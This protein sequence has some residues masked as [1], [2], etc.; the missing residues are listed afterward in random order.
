MLDAL[1][2]QI[3]DTSVC[4]E[5]NIHS[6]FHKRTHHTR[7]LADWSSPQ[8]SHPRVEQD[9]CHRVFCRRAFFLFISSRKRTYIIGRVVIRNEL[10][11]VCHAL[12]DIVFSYELYPLCPPVKGKGPSSC[13]IYSRNA[14]PPHLAV[15]HFVPPTNLERRLLA[16]LRL[17]QAAER[18]LD[19]SRPDIQLR[20]KA[21]YAS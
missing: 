5:S 18:V 3:G 16:L 19:P 17:A 4:F 11:G 1:V 14:T 6:N 21:P 8:S 10:E 15:K 7:I 9:L 2:D 13:A 20:D 12:N